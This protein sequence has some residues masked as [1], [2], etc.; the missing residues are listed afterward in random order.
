M[1]KLLR[2][3][4]AVYRA[5]RR[6]WQ[7]VKDDEKVYDMLSK[8]MDANAGKSY[9]HNCYKVEPPTLH[10]T[11]EGREVCEDCYLKKYAYCPQCDTVGNKKAGVTSDKD[12]LCD[13]IKEQE[14]QSE[15]SPC[16]ILLNAFADGGHDK[17][18]IKDGKSCCLDF[19]DKDKPEPYVDD[20][21]LNLFPKEGKANE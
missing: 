6:A 8:A 21:T 2:L 17:W 5:H 16:M 18:I 15:D 4:K 9:C 14:P 1:K 10:T 13:C 7:D 20:K 11:N 12:F 19:Q 3:I